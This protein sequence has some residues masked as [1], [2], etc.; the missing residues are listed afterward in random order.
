MKTFKV[1]SDVTACC[2]CGCEPSNDVWKW[3]RKHAKETGHSP[4]VFE[5][6]DVFSENT[7]KDEST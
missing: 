6:Y 1:K 4:T 3:A 7:L 2:E 5:Q